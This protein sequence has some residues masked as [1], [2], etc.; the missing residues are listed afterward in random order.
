MAKIELT[1]EEANRRLT[2]LTSQSGT[3]LL[4]LTGGSTLAPVFSRVSVEH[5][6]LIA[7]YAD[8]LADYYKDAGEVEDPAITPFD[9]LP[10]EAQKAVKEDEKQAKAAEQDEKNLSQVER[11][12]QISGQDAPKAAAAGKQAD[13]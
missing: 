11:K 8:S 5:L 6:Q 9:Q 7:E 13:K 1:D 3:Q 2:W 12:D 4:E 10:E